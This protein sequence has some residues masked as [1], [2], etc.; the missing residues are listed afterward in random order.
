[1]LPL[2]F[3]HLYYFYVVARQ[4][5]FSNAAREL[6]VSQSSISVQIR[7]FEANLGHTLFNRLKTGVELTES[8]QVVFQFA[9]EIFHDVDRIWTDLEVMERRISGTFSIGTINSFGIYT[10]P[11]LLRT[12]KDLYPEVKVGIEAGS[13]RQVIEMVQNGRTDFAVLSANRKYTGLSSLA[14]KET[15]MFLVAPQGHEL[16]ERSPVKPAVLEDYPF[17]GYEEGMETRMMMDAYFRRLSLSVEYALESSNTAT[18]KHMVMEGL[19][20]S[21]LPETAVGVEIRQ[22]RLVRVDVQGLYLTQKLTL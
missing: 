13:A 5:S 2:N 10:L 6:R 22:G 21:V 9:E 7:Q 15:K 19:G 1:M 11:R 18:I 14:L 8:G 17:I 12:F 3:N 20:I 16:A 4:G